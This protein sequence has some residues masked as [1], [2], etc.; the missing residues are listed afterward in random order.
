MIVK[1]TSHEGL[2]MYQRKIMAVEYS[3]AYRGKG[4]L[5]M[6]DRQTID[7]LCY[8]AFATCASLALVALYLSG[9]GPIKPCELSDSDGYMHLLRASDLHRTGR[10]YDP[11]IE[12][13]NPPHGDRLHWT[14]PFDVLL[15]VGAVPG[16][17]LTTS[18][19]SSLFWWGVV[20]S[21]LLLVASL[22]AV[23][24]AVYPLLGDDGSPILGFLF[25]AQVA[26]MS[27]FQAG[28]PDH[29]SLLELLFLLIAGYALRLIER[30]FA[31]ATC[32]AAGA[33]SALSL[34]VSVES[35]VAVGIALAPLVVLWVLRGSDFSR[36]AFHYSASLF[37]FAGA[38]LILER[39]WRD[40]TTMELD[41]LSIVHVG[42]FG[43]ITTLWLAI[44]MLAAHD[45]LWQRRNIRLLSVLAAV[46]IL[47]VATR[48]LLPSFFRG[49]FGD[50]PS[51]M[52][53]RCIAHIQEM[54]PLLRSDF[55]L[56]CGVPLL[57]YGLTYPALFFT[58]ATHRRDSRWIFMFA[59]TLLFVGLSLV[60][61]RWIYY[62]QVL[63]LPPATA[64][65]VRMR[66]RTAHHALGK[67]LTNC[68]ITS[69]FIVLAVSGS[70]IQYLI[71][72]GRDADTPPSASVKAVCE[73]LERDERWQGHCLRIV[74][75]L[76]FGAEILYRTHH[77]VIATLYHRNWQGILE[78]YDILTAE[79]NEQAQAH[80]RDRQ[81]DLI[82]LGPGANDSSFFRKP[83]GTSTLYQ[84][85][86]KS[87][88][89]S[90]CQEVPL[91]PNLAG[92]RLFETRAP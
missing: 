28:R 47:A 25:V 24:W 7:R 60:Q 80:I 86:C 4:I 31:A 34:W 76:N 6:R 44:R 89:P 61:A 17:L 58:S 78:T 91:P 90:W 33:V 51:E 54:Q 21:P 83:D 3:V 37:A 14:R 22:P 39:P 20:L 92:F 73:Y 62:A 42:V 65:I 12:R 88:M 84:R 2:L 23:R 19:D 56:M 64:L 45:W 63:I 81:I 52:M 71:Q 41:R 29:H 74:T 49:P 35:L 75:H 57:G 59:A 68:G 5:G 66:A 79:T 1:P 11:V 53:A 38:A 15:L 43:I 9:R 40:L 36:K 16:S 69:L 8:L 50:V 27:V 26:I 18:F 72:A 85:L 67:L 32:Y 82:L 70:V 55:R 13:S 87:E 46:A 30:P 48:L 10:W 77:E